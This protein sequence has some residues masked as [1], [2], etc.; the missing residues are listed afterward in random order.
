VSRLRTLSFDMRKQDFLGQSFHLDW[1]FKS[2]WDLFLRNQPF[3]STKNFGV[4]SDF[5]CVTFS[6]KTCIGVPAG[7]TLPSFLETVYARVANLA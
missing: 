6:R 7:Q 5:C 2:M 1:W 4:L 3:N